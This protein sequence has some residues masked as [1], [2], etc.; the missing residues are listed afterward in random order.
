MISV[1][2]TF[3]RTDTLYVE[4]CGILLT[5]ALSIKSRGISA[6]KILLFASHNSDMKAVQKA[7]C[8]GWNNLCN[9]DKG[10]VP[11]SYPSVHSVR[12]ARNN[13]DFLKS[14]PDRCS[15]APISLTIWYEKSIDDEDLLKTVCVPLPLLRQHITDAPYPHIFAQAFY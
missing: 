11:E 7:I 15:E 3:A 14:L 2:V 8:C 4:S 1:K 5:N 9:A 13:L 12:R 6:A 10:D